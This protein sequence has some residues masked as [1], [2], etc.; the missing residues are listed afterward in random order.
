M[1][2]GTSAAPI[3]DVQVSV[4]CIPTEKPESDGTL[5]WD[6]TTIVVARV[7]AGGD[8]GIGFTYASGAAARVVVRTLAP[9]ISGMDAM[10][11]PAVW[12]K[13][14]REIRNI[15]QSGVAFNAVS[16]VDTALW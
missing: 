8:R 11:I 5:A 13:M 9:A 1:R 12:N 3:D 10:A 16:A 6:R 2:T 7:S 14:C 15:G 4:F